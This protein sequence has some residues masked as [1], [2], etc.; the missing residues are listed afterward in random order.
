MVR[1]HSW[2]Q[3]FHRQSVYEIIITVFRYQAPTTP[4]LSYILSVLGNGHTAKIQGI[5]EALSHL[6]D[7]VP[8]IECL[9]NLIA[10]SLDT[11][12][13][14]RTILCGWIVQLSKKE[15]SDALENACRHG[16]ILLVDNLL[17]L[18]IPFKEDHLKYI[19]VSDLR[20]ANKM[21]NK[22]KIVPD[23]SCL[24][25]ACEMGNIEAIEMILGYRVVPNKK[26]IH[27]IINHGPNYYHT[28]RRYRRHNSYGGKLNHEQINNIIDAMVGEGYKLTIADVE[29]ATA[30]QLK[31]ER[32]E[33]YGIPMDAKLLSICYRYD[34]FPYDLPGI[35]P[36]LECIKSI[37][38]RGQNLKQI[39]KA[40]K[41]NHVKLDTECLLNA[42][43]HAQNIAVVRY[44]T[45]VQGLVPDVACCQ[46]IAM[47]LSKAETLNH[48]LDVMKHKEEKKDLQI[49]SL[50]AELSKYR[51]GELTADTT[52]VEP[53]VDTPD[54]PQLIEESEDTVEP[55]DSDSIFK[56]KKGTKNAKALVKNAKRLEKK[57][58]KAKPGAVVYDTDKTVI[59]NIK[60]M[61]PRTAK[62]KFSIPKGA[63]EILGTKKINFITA[64]E[65]ILKIIIKEKLISDSNRN[66]FVL[67]STL[68]DMIGGKKGDIV[69]LEQLDQITTKLMTDTSVKKSKKKKANDDEFA[70]IDL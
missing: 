46:E 49:K 20:L 55:T 25:Y 24:Q 47:R 4:Q 61:S 33:L 21:M 12:E 41:D 64:R 67:N 23:I 50:K 36:D 26:C 3:C 27:A 2:Y 17:E 56:K 7:Y 58:K 42:C 29:L 59:L 1:T 8:S 66:R 34:F 18:D 22:Y 48:I 13:P 35:V 52:E 40:L 39:Q 30:R 28:S 10:Y 9:N 31:L 54:K 6:D 38:S 60:S 57:L 15:K 68:A 5:I 32:I 51:K 44:L 14:T 45:D 43:K 69:K 63:Q 19:I 37:C 11:D 53:D 70:P 16:K 62:K 65:I